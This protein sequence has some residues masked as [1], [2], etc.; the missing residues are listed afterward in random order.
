MEDKI[1][2]WKK[3]REEGKCF[4]EIAKI[5]GVS[6][7][8]IYNALGNEGD[9]MEDNIK[10]L[11]NKVDKGFEEVNKRLNKFEKKT[12]KRFDKVEG[13]IS[14]LQIHVAD[15][16]VGQ[17]Q[18]ISMLQELIEKQAIA[19]NQI[20]GLVKSQEDFKQEQAAKLY[21]LEDR[22]EALETKV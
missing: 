21:R 11:E 12:D 20:V 4:P 3:M 10:K 19:T 16:K 14:N 2:E 17:T 1:N 6:S 18:I 7:R 15:L 22:I 9:N 5:Y 13:D 8:E